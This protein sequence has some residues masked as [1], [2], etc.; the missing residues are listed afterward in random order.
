MQ[1][2]YPQMFLLLF[3]PTLVLFYLML[4]S[5]G[6]VMRIFSPEVYEKLSLAE[7]SSMGRST[8]IT[9]IFIALLLMITAF[10]RPVIDRGEREVVA[11]GSEIVIGLDISKSMDAA[12]IYPSRFQAAVHKIKTLLDFMGGDK[13]A[14][15][16][17]AKDSYIVSPMTRDKRV[18]GYLLDTFDAARFE[19]RGSNME[20]VVDGTVMLSTTEEKTLLIL[21]DGDEGELAAIRE[22]VAKEGIRVYAVG[23]AET[24]GSPIADGRGYLND[25]EGNI[26][27]SS[28]NPALKEMAIES[29]GAYTDFTLSPDDILQLYAQIQSDRK[30]EEFDKEKIRDFMEL[31]YYPLGMAVFLLLI[32][33]HSL[34]Q[35]NVTAALLL[36]SLLP[37]P[38]YGASFD[39]GA[40]SD[41]EVYYR[42]GEYEKAADAYGRIGG[43]DANSEAARLHDMGNSYYKLGQYDKAADAYEKSLK[44]E[45]NDD[46]R[47]NL[48]L[49]KKQIEKQKQD[50]E[51]QEQ[52]DQ[53]ND[54]QKKDQ[55][56]REKESAEEYKKSKEEKGQKQDEQDSAPQEGE[57]KKEEGEPTDPKAD[58]NRKISEQ[59]EW[60][61]MN[62]L[63]KKPNPVPLK[64]LPVGKGGE[65]AKYW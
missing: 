12:D 46:T 40:M 39:F 59:Q 24:K 30:A 65:S 55:K 11:K 54:S 51:Q 56:S 29:G 47:H 50:K 60:R 6:K 28:L 42:S 31:F 63:D 22:R 64:K 14:I 44:Q 9:I 61:W 33:F 21:S 49:A 35:R 26:V 57:S 32:A 3:I 41:A 62:E 18:A 34:P 17:F 19:D 13:V 4:T 16:A 15:L 8:R 2:M 20:A 45:K 43:L 36:L 27:I 58:E 1:F 25:R 10:A 23:M 37:L 48:E 7:I 53:K 52:Q 5:Q 38:G